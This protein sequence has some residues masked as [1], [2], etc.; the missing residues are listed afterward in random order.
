[1]AAFGITKFGCF[2]QEAAAQIASNVP[3]KAAAEQVI[4]SNVVTSL[5]FQVPAVTTFYEV[6][7]YLN[8]RGDGAVGS[9]VTAILTWIGPSGDTHTAT[10]LVGGTVAG[11]AQ[12][13]VFPILAL[14]GSTVSIVSSF[15]TTP[16]HYDLAAD[17]LALAAQ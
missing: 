2:T 5:S 8:S 6:P 9:S 10:L 3:V 12:L 16:F 1:M 11:V 14:A 15:A 17:C 13:E 4:N 7:I